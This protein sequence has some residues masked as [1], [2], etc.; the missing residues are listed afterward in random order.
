MSQFWSNTVELEELLRA[1]AREIGFHAL[2]FARAEALDDEVAHLDRWLDRGCHA[3]MTYL[4]RWREVRRDPRHSGMVAGAK[5]VVSLAMAYPSGEGRGLGRELARY[6]RGPDYHKVLRQRLTSLLRQLRQEIPELRGRALVDSAPVLERAW[7]R[8]AGLGWIG[9][10]SCLIHPEL[11]SFFVLGELILTAEINAEPPAPLPGCGD[12]RACV[13]A[14]PTGAL[15]SPDGRR[16]DA[17]R[18]LSYWTVEAP[19]ALPEELTAQAPLFGCDRCQLACP[20]NHRRP[21]VTSPLAPLERW[22]GLD[23][24]RLAEMSIEE[25]SRLIR[26]TAL[27]RAGAEALRRRARAIRARRG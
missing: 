22:E 11:G 24:V 19:G 20:H 7:A 16:L 13:E 27:E 2:G 4:E 10:N 25:I 23:L 21:P 8:R 1:R 3:G 9:R 26:G 17:R 18:C 14:C 5:T 15:A 6:A 12:C